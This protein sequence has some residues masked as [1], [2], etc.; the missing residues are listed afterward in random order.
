[1]ASPAQLAELAWEQVRAR[2]PFWIAVVLFLWAIRKPVCRGLRWAWRAALDARRRRLEGE[3]H[4]FRVFRRACR[5]GD[6]DGMASTFW[7]WRD[8]IGHVPPEGLRA[9]RDALGEQRAILGRFERA[10]YG[11]DAAGMPAPR[12]VGSAVGKLRRA[13][14][15]QA[16]PPTPGDG[17]NPV[18]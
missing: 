17:L 2:G 1:V 7:R 16:S 3:A 18:A 15:E 5:R 12:E 9:A 8:R 10:R 14:R 13:L 6:L 11:R 4:A